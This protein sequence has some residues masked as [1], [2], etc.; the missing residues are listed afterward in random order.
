MVI[1][2]SSES[3]LLSVENAL[4]PADVVKKINKMEKN[5]PRLTIFGAHD[6]ESADVAKEEIL[7]K[8]T[9]LKTLV[10]NN[11]VFEVLFMKKGNGFSNLIIKVDPEIRKA[12][13]ENGAKLYL[14]LNRC[15][16]SDSFPFKVC[17]NCQ[18]TCCHLSDKCPLKNEKMVCRFCSENHRSADC[19]VKTNVAMHKC[20]NCL[21]SSNNKIKNNGNSH[22]SNSNEC[23]LVQ[24]IISNIKLNTE[25]ESKNA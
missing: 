6:V 23:P 24:S 19:P 17:Y 25:Y 14:G 11:K 20:V 16:V 18:K 12:I 15:R 13:F 1:S 2:C 9:F 8:N 21:D 4:G 7:C 22:Y 10:D 5:L 3:E